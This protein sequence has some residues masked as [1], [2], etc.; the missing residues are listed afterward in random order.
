MVCDKVRVAKILVTGPDIKQIETEREKNIAKL[1]KIIEGSQA[2]RK[3]L[4][5]RAKLAEKKVEEL[6]LE[7]RNIQ[8]NSGKAREEIN[9][10]I[11]QLEKENNKLVEEVR[12]ISADNENFAKQLRQ[13]DLQLTKEVT[14]SDTLSSELIQYRD[15]NIKRERELRNNIVDLENELS[16]TKHANRALQDQ[17]LDL[18]SQITQLIVTVKNKDDD[19]T[20]LEQQLEKRH[21]K[22]ESTEDDKSHKIQELQQQI[23]ML[24]TQLQEQKLQNVR[25]SSPT[26]KVDLELISNEA[27]QLRQ[28]LAAKISQLTRVNHAIK[29]V[30]E[31]IL[32]ANTSI[33]TLQ[34]LESD[35]LKLHTNAVIHSPK[36]PE[37]PIKSLDYLQIVSKYK[38]ATE[39]ISK[40]VSNV[41]NRVEDIGITMAIGSP[42]VSLNSSLVTDSFEENPRLLNKLHSELKESR[43]KE[44]NLSDALNN[45]KYLNSLL[46]TE[47]NSLKIS[48]SDVDQKTKNQ[49]KDLRKQLKEANRKIKSNEQ[50]ELATTKMND[51]INYDKTYQS[52][53]LVKHLSR[54]E[55]LESTI[56]ELKSKLEKEKSNANELQDLIQQLQTQLLDSQT[57]TSDKDREHETTIAHNRKYKSQIVD[58]QSTNETLIRELENMK[59][60][61]DKRIELLQ[62]EIEH[63]RTSNERDKQLYEKHIS[64][65]EN[66]IKSYKDQLAL[67]EQQLRLHTASDQ[68]AEIAVR[69]KQTQFEL[70]LK[71][72]QSEYESARDVDM[73]R[74]KELKKE[75]Q[76]ANHTVMELEAKIAYLQDQNDRLEQTKKNTKEIQ[77][78]LEVEQERSTTLESQLETHREHIRTLELSLLDSQKLLF[79]QRKQLDSDSSELGQSNE[80]LQNTLTELQKSLSEKDTIIDGLQEQI[81]KHTK[82]IEDQ[83]VELKSNEQEIEKLATSYE[84]LKK[85]KHALEENL[86]N[87]DLVFKLQNVLQGKDIVIAGMEDE[88][89]SFR[90]QLLSL[91]QQCKDLSN[92]LKNIR[93]LQTV[94]LDAFK[95]EL[96]TI[97]DAVKQYESV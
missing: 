58:L 53:Q 90:V 39:T 7:R 28:E 62:E 29:R 59:K 36:S 50:I 71:E 38:Q 79:D 26:E 83:E 96:E 41:K 95:N 82:Y 34:A 13:K 5:E 65:N 24:Q 1:R 46:Q 89:E 87:S 88:R 33:T 73:K 60:D 2:E 93:I 52:E 69:N 20:I 57:S 30:D 14:R 51:L 72:M 49:I 37:T 31:A 47:I 4:L 16:K 22:A 66:L 11:A 86:D 42:N 10:Y 12:S 81:E 8:N 70:K 97:T 78:Q 6:V 92:I 23:L 84:T 21:E 55:E 75:I 44:Q 3:Q 18:R 25:I 77:L 40:A 61:V 68:D 56:R 43:M 15:D 80:Q 54:I 9:A 85:Q 74:M 64:D 19:I 45:S 48:L 91:F 76:D 63:M 67:K 35:L 17:M 27:M 32:D 94:E